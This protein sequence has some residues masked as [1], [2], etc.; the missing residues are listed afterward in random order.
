M[1][2]NYRWFLPIFDTYPLPIMRADVIRY[3]LLHHFGGIFVDLDVLC[4]KPFSGLVSNRELIL[5]I[6]P[7]LYV[8]EP[9]PGREFHRVLCNAVMASRPGHPFWGHVFL[10]LV[11]FHKSNPPRNQ[12]Y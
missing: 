7:E 6:E 5:G 1:E 3:F 10:R 11:E 8:T 2:V 9:V 4:L 12:R